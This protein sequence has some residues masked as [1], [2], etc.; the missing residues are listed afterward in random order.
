[1]NENRNAQIDNFL[2]KWNEMLRVANEI[3]GFAFDFSVTIHSENSIT[4]D[5]VRT[6]NGINESFERN[7][8]KWTSDV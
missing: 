3:E 4:E 6:I 1:M 7:G 5:R 2:E 8:M